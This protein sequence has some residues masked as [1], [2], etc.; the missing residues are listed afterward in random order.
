MGEYEITTAR[1]I[2]ARRNLTL[3][4][5]DDSRMSEFSNLD[6]D[7]IVFF[8]LPIAHSPNENKIIHNE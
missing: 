8:F 6:D 4:K 5:P 2:M 1:T 7:F 3:S